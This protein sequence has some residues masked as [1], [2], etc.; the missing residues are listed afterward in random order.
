MSAA[1]ATDKS[2][3]ST[4]I[5]GDTGTSYSLDIP[6]KL[7]ISPALAFLYRPFTSL[8]SHASSDVLT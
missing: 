5:S 6:V 2:S 3:V 8:F 1:S 4:V 7:G